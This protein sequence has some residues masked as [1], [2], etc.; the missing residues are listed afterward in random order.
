MI[1][2]REHQSSDNNVINQN[3]LD[4]FMEKVLTDLGGAASAVLVYVGDKLGYCK[5]MSDAGRPI[6]S[7]EL[8][9]M[10]K[11]YESNTREWL[12]NPEVTRMLR[13]PLL[14]EN[15]LNLRYLDS[16]FSHRRNFLM[17][18]CVRLFTKYSPYRSK[19]PTTLLF[20]IFVVP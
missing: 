3:E 19:S 6:T 13:Y 7:Q 14:P 5:A 15:L 11:T 1:N 8:S 4:Q 2:D 12:A 17:K 18:F 9:V 20:R 10:T 16:S